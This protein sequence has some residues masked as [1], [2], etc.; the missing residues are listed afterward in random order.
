M[1]HETGQMFGKKRGVMVEV[2]RDFDK[3]L[4]IFKKKVD[5]E[6]VLKDYKK[7]DHFLS[8]SQKKRLKRAEAIQLRRKL[9]RMAN[10]PRKPQTIEYNFNQNHEIVSEQIAKR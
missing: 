8:K 10:S 2:G 9:E 5:R 1:K 3:A 4:K 6:R 7:K